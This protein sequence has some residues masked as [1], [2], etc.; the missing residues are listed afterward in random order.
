MRAAHDTASAV[1]GIPMEDRQPYISSGTWSLLGV[2]TPAP[3][4]DEAS[5]CGNWSNEGGVGY[6]RYQKKIMGMWLVQELCPQKDF[7]DIV[8]EAEQST[9]DGT[10]NANAADFLAPQSMKAAFDN[11]LKAPSLSEADY[12]AAL[13]NIILSAPFF[14]CKSAGRLL[15]DLLLPFFPSDICFDACDHCCFLLPHILSL[16]IFLSWSLDP[17]ELI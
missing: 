11:A 15:S 13:I 16:R 4:T 12:F 9:F 10:I 1:D 7:A 6:N 14:C 8:R 2:K 3:V 17:V 5:R